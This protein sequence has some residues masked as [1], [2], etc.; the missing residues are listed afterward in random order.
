MIQ[1]L[2]DEIT[3]AIAV[4]EGN[5]R[6]AK[7]LSNYYQE[8]PQKPDF[9]LGSSC[10]QHIHEFTHEL[11]STIEKMQIDLNRAKFLVKIV[12]DRKGLVCYQPSSD[13]FLISPVL[14]RSQILQYL[15]HQENEKTNLLTISM[16]QIG[17]KSHREALAMS[18]ITV[19]TLVYLPGT[20]VSVSLFHMSFCPLSLSFEE[21]ELTLD[22]EGFL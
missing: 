5:I 4:L 7:M 21:D 15:Q 2:E 17:L 10:G 9:L 12:A 19:V 13:Y 6:V 11:N 16:R 18:I 8:L 14:I 22:Q 20:F 3:L 1:L